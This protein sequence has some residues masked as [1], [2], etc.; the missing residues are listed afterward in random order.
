MFENK[1]DLF[2]K[3]KDSKNER[4]LP[5]TDHFTALS[6]TVKRSTFG[7]STVH[8]EDAEE[9]QRNVLCLSSLVT[10]MCAPRLTP[11][12]NTMRYYIL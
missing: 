8:L 7:S 2:S 6:N 3:I 1:E 12:N 11:G 10:S 4:G 5:Q 9:V